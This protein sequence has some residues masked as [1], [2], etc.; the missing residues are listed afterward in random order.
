[1][2]F[3]E[4][5]RVE[6]RAVPL[7]EPGP[8]EVLVRTAFSGISP[9]T[10]MLAYR[11]ELD[12][13]VSVDET[14]PALSGRFRFPFR[15]GYSCVGRVEQPGADLAEGAA[16]FAFHPHQDRFVVAAGDAI[17]I[18]DVD[19]RQATLFPLV[20]TALQVSLETEAE[21]EAIIVVTGLGVVG[22]LCSLLLQQGGARVL[23]SDPV[24]SRR[25]LAGTLGIESVAPADLQARVTDAT[26]T[27]GAP[28]LVEAS[29]NPSALADGLEL[30]AHEGT[31]LVVSW[32]GTKPVPLPLGADFHRRRLTIRSSQVST[33]PARLAGAW[34]LDRRR[35]AARALLNEL[36]LGEL[37]THQIPF[38]S[39]P[40]AFGLV[41]RGAP[42]LLHAALCY[43]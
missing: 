13:R 4:A 38:R 27:E 22:L 14:L 2:W 36:P 43:E 19:L 26:S 6:I 1:V 9:G 10:E 21:P 33:I 23:A 7:T 32:Y 29:G 42:G 12:E 34:S 25:E 18:G 41:D 31:A 8:D 35:H 30:L 28:L 17:E 3:V 20:E 5:H 24:A 39:A 11:G 37:A 40:D 15:Y 16:V